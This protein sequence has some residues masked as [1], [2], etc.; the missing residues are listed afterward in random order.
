MNDEE[1]ARLERLERRVN[2]LEDKLANVEGQPRFREVTMGIQSPMAFGEDPLITYI[3]Q[4]KR[5]GL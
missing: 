4:M 2:R 5:G 1:L 3:K